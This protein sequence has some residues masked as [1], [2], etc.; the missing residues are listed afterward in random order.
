[1]GAEKYYHDAQPLQ[2]RHQRVEGQSTELRKSQIRAASIV[3]KGGT[4]SVGPAA[5]RKGC[6]GLDTQPQSGKAEHDVPVRRMSR[7]RS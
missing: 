1:M 7:G 4:A 2:V 3:P 6:R 5:V